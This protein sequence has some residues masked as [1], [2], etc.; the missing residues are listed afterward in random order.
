MDKGV[1]MKSRSLSIWWTEF[2]KHAI[3]AFRRLCGSRPAPPHERMYAVGESKIAM[4][5]RGEA[6]LPD[7]VRRELVSMMAKNLSIT[8]RLESR[9]AAT[10]QTQAN[11]HWV[12]L[13]RVP[14]RS[15]KRR[16]CARSV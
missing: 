4:C 10:A 12:H 2:R 16:G 14:A 7:Y 6:P 9:T 3:A 15:A 8:T 11:E 5:V 13:R 1:A